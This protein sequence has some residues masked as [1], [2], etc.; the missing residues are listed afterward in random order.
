MVRLLNRKLIQLIRHV[1]RSTSIHV[2]GRIDRVGWRV[3]LVRHV[4]LAIIA[5]AIVTKTEEVSLEATMT[6]GGNMIRQAAELAQLSC[7]TCSTA[8]AR[9][10]IDNDHQGARTRGL[11]LDR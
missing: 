1:I 3:T 4:D 6:A 2:P 9:P 11:W 7:T 10:A 8:S 5:F